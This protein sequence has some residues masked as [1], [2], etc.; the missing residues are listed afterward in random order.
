[1]LF[2][3]TTAIIFYS[4][5]AMQFLN[6]TYAQSSINIL[7]Y[8]GN[9]YNSAFRLNSLETNPG[10]YSNTN[11]WELN[12]L[13]GGTVSGKSSSNIYTL[14]LAKTI[15]RH[16]LYS[17]YT[18]GFEKNFVFNTGTTILLSD[19][20]EIE[21]T[22]KTTLQYKEKFGFG[23]SYKFSSNFS[24][25]FSVR[26]FDQKFTEE[27]AVPVFTDSLNSIITQTE[28]ESKNYWRGDIGINYNPAANLLLNLSSINLFTLK[29][30]T[31]SENIYE[32]NVEK[33]ALI[34]LSYSPYK[35][36]NFH[37]SYE[38][39]GGITGGFNLATEMFDGSLTAGISLIH[40]KDIDNTIAGIIPVLNYST[41]LFSLTLSG[42]KYFTSDSQNLLSSFL[43]K[44]FKSI[45][46]N[47]YSEDK[48]F[49]GINFAL[50]FKKKKSADLIEVE[51]KKEIFPTMGDIYLNEPF[52]VGKVTNITDK[53]VIV[54]PSSLIS[55]LSD[56]IIF[57][58]DVTISAGDTVLV[59]F[60][61]II[62][63]NLSSGR[64]EISQANFYV[65]VINGEPDDEIQKPVLINNY[66]SWDGKVI[67]LRYFVY[68]DL[69]FAAGYAKNILTRQKE[70]ILSVQS[71][72]SIFKKIEVLFNHFVKE[73]IYVSDPRSSVEYVQFPSE[74][75][76][77]KGGDCDDLSVG[78]ASLLE[79]IGIETAFVD[80]KSKAG[81][82]HVNLLI[83][84]GLAPMEAH[85]ITINDK[86]Y[87]VREDKNGNDQVWIP[88][89]MTSLTDFETGWSLGSE[90][91]Y[92]EAVENFGLAKNEVEIIDVN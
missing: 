73:M 44:R 15:S 60:Y 2:N 16:N 62:N 72:L 90:K 43:D 36:L 82:S 80:Y 81:I 63:N 59:P 9:N 4:W 49:L 18:P 7:G 57:S 92:K 79:S 17:R 24:A 33:G 86:K 46:N 30:N 14:S 53:P 10:N 41:G 22:L 39:T 42:I 78:F 56:E 11:D 87:F 40:D 67:N 69:S 6:N 12:V 25:G 5:I 85:L 8:A 31:G 83:N 13:F 47:K 38:T 21:T 35:Y 27:T 20:E 34:G 76:N 71:S 54:K 51:I 77:V 37:S 28:V 45:I 75:I 61:T 52:A 64:R 3:K 1:L 58:P 66:N 29:E 89:E 23:Y 19:T 68:K 88:V 91:F 26:Y 84:T 65:T 48:I 70:N 74:T 50:S 55:N 32:M